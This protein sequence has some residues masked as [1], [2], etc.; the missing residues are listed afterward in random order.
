[1][2]AEIDDETFLD[3]LKNT[4]KEYLTDLT[5]I[6][7]TTLIGDP[8]KIKWKLDP[9]KNIKEQIADMDVTLLAKTVIEL[10]GD[11]TQILPGDPATGDVIINKEIL[12][13]HKESVDAAVEN[14]DSF[15]KNMI[16]AVSQI[17]KFLGKP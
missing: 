17:R 3:D 13:L 12:Q 8:K 5:Y 16:E 4:I 2:S 14:W 1:M 6:D 10:D 15:V 7:V 11:I 9:S